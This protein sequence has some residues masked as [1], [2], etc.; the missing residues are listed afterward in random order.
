MIQFTFWAIP[1]LFGVILVASVFTHVWP[2]RSEPGATAF[3]WMSGASAWWL[4]CQFIGLFL[5]SLDAKLLLAQLQY[6]G[7]SAVPVAWLA[8]AMTYTGRGRQL[9]SWIMAL[10]YGVSATTIL[11]AF[12]NSS[13]GLIWSDV[14]LVQ[15]N[16]YSGLSLNHGAWFQVHV[17]MTY[18]LIAVATG[19][20][21]LHIAQSPRHWFRLIFV[22]GAPVALAIPSV[23]YLTPLQPQVWVDLTPTG[24]AVANGLLGWGLMRKGLLDFA[25]VA[26]T[27]V[28]EEMRDCV[29]VVDRSGR[30]V[31]VNRAAAQL[32]GVR[33]HGPVP[34]DLGTAW[35]SNRGRGPGEEPEPARIEL[36]TTDNRDLKF[37]MSV[38]ALGPQEGRGRSV[39]VLRDITERMRIEDELRETTTKL[40]KANGELERRANTD[41]LTGLANRRHFLDVLEREIERA[42]RYG[43]PLALI[44]LDLDHFKRVNDNYGHAAGDSVLK[45]AAAALNRVSR[46]TDLPARL[47]GEELALLLPETHVEGASQMAERLRTLIAAE[48]HLSPHGTDFSVTSSFGVAA[49]MAGDG[50]A[51]DLMQR[52]DEALYRA[53]A[54]GRDRV[55]TIESSRPPEPDTGSEPDIGSEPDTEGERS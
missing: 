9:R 8:Y 15:A 28:V 33:V 43:R 26:R 27:T 40:E 51:V 42:D 13:H 1:S 10:I 30:I 11:L 44:M 45:A 49:H 38:A 21:G 4:V 46:D 2:Q 53:K 35:I 24:L 36:R 6:V 25:P 48:R 52:S 50:E 5:S 16:G 55:V 47:G 23:I 39:L 31:D 12:T 3:L 54:E 7:I 19:A 17:G 34:I 41:G 37:E 22:I 18:A 14:S 32:L 20:L 29:I